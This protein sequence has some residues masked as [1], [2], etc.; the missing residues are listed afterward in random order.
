MLF[1]FG[2]M[3]VEPVHVHVSKGRPSA[4]STKIWLT[5]DGKCEI[6]NNN[7][8]IPQRVLNDILEVIQTQWAE[9]IK[10]W[11]KIFGE[12]KFCC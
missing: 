1:I 2:Q 12:V 4:N 11:K 9:I 6:A 5:S 3:K 10:L 7:S 8:R